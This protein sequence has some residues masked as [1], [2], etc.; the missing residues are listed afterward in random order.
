M[1]SFASSATTCGARKP[2]APK[3]KERAKVGNNHGQLR[4]A[5]PPRVAHATPP[6]PIAPYQTTANFCQKP[7]QFMI[8]KAINHLCTGTNQWTMAKVLYVTTTTRL[9]P[10]RS[11]KKPEPDI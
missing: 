4:I 6:E 2:P 5:M 9:R 10:D 7:W 8:C 1:A 3:K 11:F